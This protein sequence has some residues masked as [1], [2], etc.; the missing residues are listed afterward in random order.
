MISVSTQSS[1][2]PVAVWLLICCVL[3]FA[4]VVLGGVTRL[5]R[6]GLSIVEWDPIMGAVP[7]LTQTRWE[8]TFDKYKQTPKY[9]KVNS[10]MSLEIGRAHV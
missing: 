10:S 7:P 9:T 6:S 1:G 4:M 8:Q 2:K 5:T 3:I